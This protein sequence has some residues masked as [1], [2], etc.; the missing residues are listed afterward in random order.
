MSKAHDYHRLAAKCVMM[1]RKSADVRVRAV[2]LH[3]A[4][5]WTKVAGEEA[6]GEQQAQPDLKKE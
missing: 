1:A 2:F 4:E 3:M 5:V 6:E